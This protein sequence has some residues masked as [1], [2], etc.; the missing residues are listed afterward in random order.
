M[1]HKAEIRA[2]GTASATRQMMIE[3]G[4]NDGIL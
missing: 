3:D 4:G 2:A 1:W